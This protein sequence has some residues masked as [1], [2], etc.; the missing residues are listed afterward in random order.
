MKPNLQ[1]KTDTILLIDDNFKRF[2]NGFNIVAQRYEFTVVGFDTIEAG[3]EYLN[4]NEKTVCA[5]LLDLSFTPNNFEGVETLHQI[6]KNHLLLPVIILTGGV[7]ENELKIAMEC[8]QKGAFNYIKKNE[9]NLDSL[10]H[11]LKFAV[12]QYQEKVESERYN[13]LKEEFRLKVISYEKMLYTT[14]LI[15]K[16]LLAEK[17][18]FTPTFEKRVKEF[19]S[20]Y[21]KLKQKEEAEGFISDPFKRIIDIAG[22]RVI[23]YNAVDLQIA[24]EILKSSDDFLDMKNGGILS[25]DDKIKTDGYRAKHFDIKLNPSKRLHLVEY[26]GLSDIPCEVQLK[27]IFAHSWSKVHHALSYK[28]NDSTKLSSEDHN[29]LNVDFIEAAKNLESI[30]QQITDICEKY[31]PST[32]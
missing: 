3:L 22:L 15:L 20:F 6:K 10:F 7:S 9:L 2:I 11:I 16:N 1:K 31:Y 21:N 32:K 14:E 28:E 24:D 13:S 23:F 19:K 17:L 18:M 25:A 30:E 4:A 29:Q 27:T 8:V 26:V 12:T 5:V